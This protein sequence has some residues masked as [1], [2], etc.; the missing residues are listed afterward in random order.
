MRLTI[1][2]TSLYMTDHEIVKKGERERGTAKN[3]LLDGG[4]SRDSRGSTSSS[5]LGRP[6]HPLVRVDSFCVWNLI[7][8]DVGWRADRRVGDTVGGGR[9]WVGARSG[10][11]SLL[12]G[13]STVNTHR[14]TVDSI[15][16]IR[17]GW[18]Y[19]TYVGSASQLSN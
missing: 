4:G 13:A 11:G 3:F 6:S 1:V 15:S 5:T 14:Q 17:E 2:S 9:H 19:E 8:F 16:K 10:L 7:T 12:P 18:M